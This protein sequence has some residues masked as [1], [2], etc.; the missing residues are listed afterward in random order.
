MLLLLSCSWREK[1][2]AQLLAVAAPVGPTADACILVHVCQLFHE[3]EQLLAAIAADTADA[4]PTWR[5]AAEQ[6]TTKQ[7]P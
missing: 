4:L 6:A 7:Q 3:L 2:A 1:A 5:T